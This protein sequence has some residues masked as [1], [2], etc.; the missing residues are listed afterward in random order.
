MQLCLK[1]ENLQLRLKDAKTL[2]LRPGVG[3]LQLR[4]EVEDLTVA[5]RYWK[6]AIAPITCG[7]HNTLEGLQLERKFYTRLV[8]ATT[9]EKYLQLRE[10]IQELRLQVKNHKDIEH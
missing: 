5:S 4:H 8:V 1:F 7:C 10:T 2:Q 9:P 3:K 6:L